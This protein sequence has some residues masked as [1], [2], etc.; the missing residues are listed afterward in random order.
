M[1]K[2][3]KATEL[4]LADK[5]V[6][7]WGA[8]R[9]EKHHNECFLFWFLSPSRFFFMTSKDSIFGWLNG[10]LVD[11]KIKAGRLAA[12]SHPHRALQG[13]TKSLSFL[14]KEVC[15]VF[16]ISWPSI[17]WWIPHQPSKNISVLHRQ[18]VKGPQDNSYHKTRHTWS[19][20]EI[21]V[22]VSKHS[23]NFF[24]HVPL[25]SFPRRTSHR[26]L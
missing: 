13:R 19:R 25:E 12:L 1:L 4:G 26:G 21:V 15:Q 11:S 18:E 24:W 2:E 8:E 7:L 9:K 14:E 6:C 10:L 16:E 5:Q 23:Q 17:F 22:S 3:A 20:S